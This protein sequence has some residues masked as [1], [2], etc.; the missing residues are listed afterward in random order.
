MSGAATPPRVVLIHAVPVAMAP[1]EA[2]FQRLWPQVQRSN[3]LDDG[4]PAALERAGGLTPELYER[5]ARLVDNAVATG[6]QGVL[7][8]CSAF[9]EAIAAA[10]SKAPIPVL[11]PDEAMFAQ[12]LRAGRRIGMLASFAPAVP[13]MERDFRTTAQALGVTVEIE[14]IC[15][16]E[17][18]EAA[19]AG[20]TAR[21]NR[22][23]A[24]AAPRL[25]HCDAVMLAQFSTSIALSDVQAVLPCPV[26]SS[27][28]AAVALLQR[29]LA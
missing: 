22:L 21:H 28:D 19:R 1:V 14:S 18:M 12:A 13:N 15:V 8:T 25:S 4:L 6:A 16:P 20:D 24:E 7:F 26:L 10:A 17:A 9:G 2:A 29:Q 11:K 23:L 5:I 3:V 27:P